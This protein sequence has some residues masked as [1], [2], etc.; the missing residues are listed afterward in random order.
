MLQHNIII[1]EYYAGIAKIRIDSQYLEIEEG[2]R[3]STSFTND[4][5]IVYDIE[6]TF[7]ISLIHKL[8]H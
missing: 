3:I 1:Y 5:I 8:R 4:N 2:V 7:K 6:H